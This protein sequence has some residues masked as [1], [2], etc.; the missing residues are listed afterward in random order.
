MHFIAEFIF[1]LSC[2][3]NGVCLTVPRAVCLLGHTDEGV[4][5]CL[6]LRRACA[7]HHHV[8]LPHGS[9]AEERPNVVRLPGKGPQ[10]ASDHAAGGGRGGGVC[11][12][13]DAHSHFHPGQG[14]RE[15]A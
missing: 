2:R 3:Y 7:H 4:R 14:A 5:V 11:H 9:E 10:P 8:L 6:C 1:F 13:L 12:L 15:R